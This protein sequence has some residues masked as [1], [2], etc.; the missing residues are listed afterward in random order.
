MKDEWQRRSHRRRLYF[1]QH[2]G[3]CG[4]DGAG[5]VAAEFFIEGFEALDEIGD[6]LARIWP[7]CGGAKMSAAAEGPMGVDGAA[8]VPAKHG[9][10]SIIARRNFFSTTGPNAERGECGLA[11]GEHGCFSSEMKLA[12]LRARNA[13]AFQRAFFEFGVYR[14]DFCPVIG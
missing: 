14:G 8:T 13:G 9:A 11:Q 6:M 12:A 1:F 7:A 5:T 2:V 3:D 4:L 10:R